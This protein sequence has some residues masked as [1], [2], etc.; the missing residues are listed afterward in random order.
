MV[1]HEI[2]QTSSSLSLNITPLTFSSD[3]IIFISSYQKSFWETFFVALF[4]YW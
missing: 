3:G 2:Q 4:F 1:F